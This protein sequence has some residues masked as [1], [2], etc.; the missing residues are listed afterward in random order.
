MSGLSCYRARTLLSAYEGG[1]LSE[2]EGQA[3]A[4]HL[5]I[6]P[7]CQET[8]EALA[9]S[10]PDTAAWKDVALEPSAATPE[11]AGPSAS[12][13]R[14]GRRRHRRVRHPMAL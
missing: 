3:V 4:D 5:W 11:L 10:L 9:P 14:V 2:V 1:A 7:S 8:R 13:D 12:H 6:C